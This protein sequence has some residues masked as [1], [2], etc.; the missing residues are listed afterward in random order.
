[1]L[2]LEVTR[3]RIIVI[4]YCDRLI[5]RVL[6]VQMPINVDKEKQTTFIWKTCNMDW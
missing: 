5:F 4:N 3:T 2:M 6:E 1:M